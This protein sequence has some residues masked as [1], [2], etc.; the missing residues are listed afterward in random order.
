MKNIFKYTNDTY[1]FTTWLFIGT[2]E[3]MTAWLK[4]KFRYAGGQAADKRH[5]A[6]AFSL[7]DDNGVICGHFIW[8]PKFDFTCHDY[9]VLVHETLRVAVQALYDR[10]V[11]T[12]QGSESEGL[13]YLQEVIFEKLLTQMYR[14]YRKEQ[15]EK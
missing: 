9:A 2:N 10:G 6:E 1:G 14:E 8:M 15:G 3:D 12:V 11:I 7:A 13:N 4:D 5:Y